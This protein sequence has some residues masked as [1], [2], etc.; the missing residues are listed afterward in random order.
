MT[1]PAPM[2]AGRIGYEEPAAETYNLR[3][4]RLLCRRRW[5]RQDIGPYVAPAQESAHHLR[6]PTAILANSTRIST[7][8]R[9]TS[10]LSTFPSLQAAP[11]PTPI[12]SSAI[13]AQRLDGRFLRIQLPQLYLGMVPGSAAGLHPVTWRA[14]RCRWRNRRAILRPEIRLRRTPMAVT[15]PQPIDRSFG[16][17]DTVDYVIPAGSSI[18]EPITYSHELDFQTPQASS[19]LS[20]DPG[21]GA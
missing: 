16:Q 18:N 2:A 14:T 10:R 1:V 13:S 6:G 15:L 19:Q 20:F 5:L 17:G 12:A 21:H 7:S 9:I 11:A 4:G 8:H 3:L